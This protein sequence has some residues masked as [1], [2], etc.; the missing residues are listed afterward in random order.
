MGLVAA[1]PGQG[2]AAA[3]LFIAALL[4]QDILGAL[5]LPHDQHLA[6]AAIQF[7]FHQSQQGGIVQILM[8]GLVVPEAL[9]LVAQF[10]LDPHR[11]DRHLL[12]RKLIRR[13]GEHRLLQPRQRRGQF[14]TEIRHIS[15]QRGA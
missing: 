2:G 15:H 6:V 12:V 14:F 9:H 8:K 5:A 4:P 13:L 10:A 11:A 3:G 1:G 7:I